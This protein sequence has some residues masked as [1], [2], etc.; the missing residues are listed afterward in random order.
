MGL[1]LSRE[2]AAQAEESGSIIATRVKPMEPASGKVWLGKYSRI[3]KA[4]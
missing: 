2:A 1:R 4:A 3:A